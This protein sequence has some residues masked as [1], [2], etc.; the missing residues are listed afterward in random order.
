MRGDYA[1]LVALANE[2]ARELGYADTGALWRSWY[3]MPP[4]QFAD[5]MDRLWLQLEPFYK[6]LHCYVRA[7]LNAK[8]G[9]AVQPRTGPIRADLLGDMWAQSWNNIYDLVEPKDLEPWL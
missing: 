8:Y 2:G 4:D 7:R 6:N 1:R 3:D 5:T 9:N